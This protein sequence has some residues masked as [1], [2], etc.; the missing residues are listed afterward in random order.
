MT[1]NLGGRFTTQEYLEQQSESLLAL[2]GQMIALERDLEPVDDGAAGV[3]SP[4]GPPRTIA[5]QR[6]YFGEYA[7][8]V[9]LEKN[10]PVGI[11]RVGTYVI[12]GDKEANLKAG[13]R[14]T[15]GDD[16]YVVT[17]LHPDVKH[18]KLGEVK[19]LGEQEG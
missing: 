3:I 10:A 7:D 12:V 11:R 17:F 9:R 8:Y 19:R 16:T 4:D 14:F 2:E 1:M 6:F 13:D 5:P 15:M 18:E